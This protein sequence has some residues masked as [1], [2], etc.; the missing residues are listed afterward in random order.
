M[1]GFVLFWCKGCKCKLGTSLVDLVDYPWAKKKTLSLP[2]PKK[3]E[4]KKKHSSRSIHMYTQQLNCIQFCRKN[5]DAN[6]VSLNIL[7]MWT[8]RKYLSHCIL[9]ISPLGRSTTNWKKTTFL[10]ILVLF[11][12]CFLILKLQMLVP[13]RNWN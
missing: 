12:L 13:H 5:L 3:K 10:F 6:H 9:S 11:Q 8:Y 2:P 7:H 4:K 1:Q